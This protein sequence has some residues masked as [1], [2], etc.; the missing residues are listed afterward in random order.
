MEKGNGLSAY[1]VGGSGWID[2]TT[3]TITVYMGGTMVPVYMGG[4]P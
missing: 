3:L 2:I 1:L 4:D